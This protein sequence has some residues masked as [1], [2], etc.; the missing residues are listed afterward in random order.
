[1]KYILLIITVVIILSLIFIFR[2]RIID[3]LKFD[4]EEDE[5]EY[6]DEYEDEEEDEYDSEY[7]KT[8]AL[9]KKGNKEKS[10]GNIDYD[11]DMHFSKIPKLD[12]D[13]RTKILSS[14]GTKGKA[15][16]DETQ[17]IS[18]PK[19]NK[20]IVYASILYN[21]NGMKK[22]FLMTGEAVF[23]GRD[24]DTCNIVISDD[25]FL[26]R[27]HALIYNKGRSVYI[28]DL[29]SKNGTFVEGEKVMGKKEIVGSKTVRLAS[30]EF[31][32]R[33]GE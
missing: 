18:I 8:E 31:I 15:N 14:I 30:T 28:T 2:N 22:E 19:Q 24:P 29:N 3:F 7:E 1:M 4:D 21:E 5:D 32:I 33:V 23:I 9:F 11:A 26:G 16:L 17:I 20:K 6:E 13:D 27:Q 25:K 12:D 10:N